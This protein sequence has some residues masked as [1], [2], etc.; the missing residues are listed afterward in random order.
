MM[1]FLYSGIEHNAVARPLET[2]KSKTENIVPV[3][4]NCNQHGQ[5]DLVQLEHQLSKHPKLLVINHASNVSGDIQDLAAIG[6]LTKQYGV[7][8]FVDAAQSGVSSIL[9]CKNLT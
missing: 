1:W 8:L 7:P 4:I 5:I 6:S 2:V 3:K 9:I